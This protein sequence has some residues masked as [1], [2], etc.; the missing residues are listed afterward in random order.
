MQ[1]FVLSGDNDES[2]LHQWSLSWGSLASLVVTVFN[3]FP[4]V[5]CFYDDSSFHWKLP[6][7]SS[8]PLA[9]T[10]KLF[11]FSGRYNHF[12]LAVTKRTSAHSSLW[13]LF[14]SSEKLTVGAIF[15]G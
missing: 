1:L 9:I 6:Q 10:L 8:A 11:E 14:P 4:C 13:R 3:T 5:N 12:V 15:S 7:D 2:V